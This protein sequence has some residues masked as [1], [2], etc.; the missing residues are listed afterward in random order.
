MASP[1]AVR[2]W[3]SPTCRTTATAWPPSC[4]ASSGPSCSSASSSASSWASSRSSSG[5]GPRQGRRGQATNGGQA[6]A[7]IILGAVAVAASVLMLIVYIQAADD[8]NDSGDDDPGYA[9]T[10]VV[11]ALPRADS[12]R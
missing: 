12:S 3:G 11:L 6:L 2:G 10:A 5:A 1:Y 9:D 7:G 4:W 8:D